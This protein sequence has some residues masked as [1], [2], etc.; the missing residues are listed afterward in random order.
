[1]PLSRVRS[2]A[3]RI[4]S[5]NVTSKN[6]TPPKPTDSSSKISTKS[7][8]NSTKSSNLTKSKPFIQEPRPVENA[9]NDPDVGL[10][11][12]KDR[13]SSFAERVR[14]A[15]RQKNVGPRQ[16]ASIE[17]IDL[18]RRTKQIQDAGGQRIHRPSTR[19]TAKLDGFEKSIYIDPKRTLD[20][21]IS[22]KSNKIV[23]PEMSVPDSEAYLLFETASVAR[24]IRNTHKTNGERYK[25]MD[26]FVASVETPT[27][28]IQQVDVGKIVRRDLMS[29]GKIC[30]ASVVDYGGD[31]T[32]VVYAV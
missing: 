13:V 1:M 16:V 14:K 32:F 2:L 31:E 26:Y 6:E 7:S 11:A 23:T 30:K 28:R 3:E 18:K 5:I 17:R 10:P 27:L 19:R 20:K 12:D 15:D 21:V 25:E 22:N 24:R 4:A 29:G 8:L 9:F